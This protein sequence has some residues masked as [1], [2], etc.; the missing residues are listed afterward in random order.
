M[1]KYL[2]TML[3]MAIFAIGFVASSESGSENQQQSDSTPTK[4]ISEEQKN[5]YATTKE[6][7]MAQAGYSKGNIYGLAA[8]G[9]EDL[10]FKNTMEVAE[11]VG[12]GDELNKNLEIMAEQEY[13]NVYGNPSTPEEEKLKKIFIKNFLKAFKELME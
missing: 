4:E 2:F 13:T 10:D 6:K 5:E 1:K 3:M 8:R 11:M 9:N 7:E 12:V